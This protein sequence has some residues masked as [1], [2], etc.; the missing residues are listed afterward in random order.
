MENSSY[1]EH[2]QIKGGKWGVM[3]GP[4][5]PLSKEVSTGK[6]LKKN[7]QEKDSKKGVASLLTKSKA[8]KEAAKKQASREESLKKA[9][10]AK[11]QKA[12]EEKKKAELK[13]KVIKSRSAAMLYKHADLFSTDELKEMSNRLFIEKQIKDIDPGFIEKGKKFINTVGTASSMLEKTASAIDNGTK[14]YNNVAKVLNSVAGTNIPYIKDPFKNNN[15]NGEKPYNENFYKYDKDNK[16]L[17]SKITTDS[18][19]TKNIIERNYT[20]T[21]YSGGNNGNKK[22]KK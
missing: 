19:G 14:T 7:V 10:D 8:K 17:Y 5:Y 11:V 4:P 22:K 3:H 20:D 15:N 12:N 1:L 9:R 13:Q 2:H 18:N 21:D 16:L 6:S